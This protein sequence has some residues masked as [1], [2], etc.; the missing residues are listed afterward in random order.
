MNVIELLRFGEAQLKAAG[1]EDP[2]LDADLLLG[3]VL[4]LPRERL[5]LARD[6]DVAAAAQAAYRALLDRR[7]RR[8]PLQYILREQEFMGL[9]FYVDERVLIPRADTE[10]L[11]EAFLNRVNVREA[12]G[13][14]VLDLCTGSGALAITAAYYRPTARVTGTDLSEEALEV[15]RF[16]AE[17][18]GVRVDWRQGDFLAPVK[19]EVWDWILTNPPY[20][21][22]A[23]YQEC[24][25]EIGFEPR[26][27]LLG[28]EDGLDFYRR[29]AREVRPLLTATGK[30]LIEI[31]WQ[32][33]QAVST[34]LRQAGFETEIILDLAGRD[35]VILATR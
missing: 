10:I 33:G 16:N 19:D 5:Y 32:Q 27:A 31:G 30:M 18:L 26:Q 3:R 7:A 11:A 34:I 23:E 8:E 2:R 13:L 17:R 1:I 12:A 14:K 9:G 20:V 15:A 4:G 22:L 21:S 24:A 35:R 29:L 25:P 28:G 6:E